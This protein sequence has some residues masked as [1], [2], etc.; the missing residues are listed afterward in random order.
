MGSFFY[1][2]DYN[3]MCYTQHYNGRPLSVILTEPFDPF[4][5]QPA[6]FFDDIP[7]I[8]SDFASLHHH[9]RHHHHHHHHQQQQQEQQ[10]R[11]RSRS[12]GRRYKRE[13]FTVHYP[14][15][16]YNSYC[17]SPPPPPPPPR[18]P[19]HRVASREVLIEKIET[20]TIEEQQRRPPPPPYM[21]SFVRTP[22][23]PIRQL[24]IRNRPSSCFDLYKESTD[25]RYQQ[26]ENR[27][28]KCVDEH[29]EE[30]FQYN[31]NYHKTPE[32]IVPIEREPPP[33]PP[34]PPP[35]PAPVPL[36]IIFHDA[37]T[38]TEDLY[39]PT[40][41]PVR[42]ET[43]DTGT[44]TAGL[45]KR[46][47]CVTGKENSSTPLIN[48][49]P[50]ET[51]IIERFEKTEKVRRDSTSSTGTL[52]KPCNVLNLTAADRKR[53]KSRVIVRPTSKPREILVDTSGIFSFPGE[54]SE[55]TSPQ[56]IE[57]GPTIKSRSPFQPPD[58]K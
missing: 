8:E 19:I 6:S 3:D 4:E 39:I 1:D 22:S 44:T 2:D 31:Y 13:Y 46:P 27:W 28:S 24:K 7:C 30:H 58:I 21:V 25:T 23:P 38:S 54:F 50:I 15:A 56:N 55:P 49:S 42:P 9:H 53:E 52:S 17:F 48:L 40:P 33:S 35:P 47:L 51:Q 14:N 36:K 45:P 34:P 43:K 37:T 32:R 11:H 12:S 10:H 5:P 29:R 26:K 16:N 41:K 57:N 20:V 18:R